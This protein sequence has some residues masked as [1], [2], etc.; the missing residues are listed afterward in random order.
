MILITRGSEPQVLI[1]ARRKNLPGLEQIIAAGRK[2]KSAEIIGYGHPDVRKA[3]WNA[4]HRKCCYC[5]KEIE[6]PY[7]DV[8]HFRPKAEADRL[9]GSTL[10]Y[11]YWWLAC[12]WENLLYACRQCNEFAKGIK[13]PLNHGSTPLIEGE[14]PP[15]QESCLLI[16][17][18][19]ESGVQHIQFKRQ[20]RNGKYAWVPE[21]RN[22]SVKGLWTV[23][24]CELDRD[25]LLEQYRSYVE[26]VV[27]PCVKEVQSALEQKKAPEIWRRVEY[28]RRVLLSRH[29][30]F[31][32]LAYDAFLHFVKPEDL[33][34]WNCSW[35]MPDVEEPHALHPRPGAVRLP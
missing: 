33:Q 10:R 17:P 19:A 7:E 6:L 24:V 21:P 34:P 30:R 4:Q 1:D 8:E 32:G 16:D 12:T 14:F 18:A 23:R 15:G 3:L 2:P 26:Q 25:T 5:E 29:R 22:N 11:G 35:P 9:P 28:A 31:V 20:R 27:M 13:F